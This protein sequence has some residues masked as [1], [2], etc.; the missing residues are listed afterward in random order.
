[1]LLRH[2]LKCSHAM[3]H[4]HGE[5]PLSEEQLGAF[6][7]LVRRRASGEPVA[8]LTSTREFY[9]R[10]FRVG[11]SVL[12]PRPETELL[13]DLALEALANVV[14]PRILDLG[15]GSGVLAITLRL[16]RPHARVTAVDS[17][18]AALDVAKGNAHSLGA[19]VNF[20][21]GDWLFAVQD[22]RF[23]A[24]VAN[25]PYVAEGD[26]H[27]RAG[28]LPWEPLHA[29]V[30]GTDGLAALRRITSTVAL[31]LDQ[32]G[33]FFTEHGFDQA[34]ACRELLSQAGLTE[35]RSWRDLAG[36]ERVSGGTLPRCIAGSP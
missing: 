31:H 10:E 5:R 23:D 22:E 35:V 36:I 25:P 26:P 2:L 3:L 17:C 21:H 8:Y 16:E 12:I 6:E 1:M 33:W 29:L 28:D 24:I 27:L 14:C 20:L 13:V 11:S 9:G 19:S 7:R 15:T 30:S 34:E 32:G 4:A 18:L